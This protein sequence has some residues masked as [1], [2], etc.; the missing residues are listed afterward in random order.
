MVKVGYVQ[1]CP[2]RYDVQ[3][4]IEAVER[5]LDGVQADVLVLPEL[6][7][8]GYAYRST[9]ELAPYAEPGDGSG[10]YLSALKQQ[11]ARTGGVIISGFAEQAP[12][13]IYNSA[14][15]V[16][17]SGVIQV[18]RK[19]HLFNRE[20][21]LFLP[22]NTGFRVFQAR[23]CTIGMMVCFDWV[24]PEAARALALRGAQLIAHPSNLVLPYCQRAMLT[25]SLENALFSIT[26][27][28]YGT[29][30]VDD[31]TLGFSGASQVVDTKGNIRLSA[32]TSG[33]AVGICEI[34]I[35]EANNK[36]MTA[37]N[38]LLEDRR[39]EWYA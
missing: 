5:L 12:E 1:F 29:E 28:R 27:N 30:S 31:V 6:A 25:R 8:S 37:L 11:A 38:H 35:S 7:N 14:A 21:L 20:K 4:N 10:R 22:G 24:F 17:A 16:D 39:P 9:A 33:D 23:G 15:A 13:G 26:T 19:T 2:M 32:G 36:M 34:D 3:A 18:Y